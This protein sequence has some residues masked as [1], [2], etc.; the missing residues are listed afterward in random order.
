LT[1]T[2]S[3]KFIIV[4]IM[5]FPMNFPKVRFFAIGQGS[6]QKLVKPKTGHAMFF[7]LNLNPEKKILSEKAE[8]KSS[9]FLKQRCY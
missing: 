7:G 8:Y 6:S 9:R 2:E 5:V 4:I 3:I 1:I